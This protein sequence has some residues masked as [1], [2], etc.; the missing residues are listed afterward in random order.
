MI[1]LQDGELTSVLPYYIKS[2]TDVQA[3]SYAYH[4]AMKR[5]LKFSKRTMLYANIDEIPEELLDLMALEVRAQ[6]Y[7]ES[8]NIQVKREIIRNSLSWYI[9]G[10]TVEAVEDMVRIVLGGGK[11]TEW[12]QYGGK[13]GT[14][15]ISTEAELSPNSI[16]KLN[17]IIDRVKNKRSQLTCVSVER[18]ITQLF[19]LAAH[20]RHY[21]HMVVKDSGLN[22]SN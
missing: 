12:Y 13:A 14:F 10:G 20:S 8:M 5:M 15:R 21:P 2:S 22:N 9:K 11:V 7:D 19:R 4:M 1:K 16:K 3:I 17:E 6:Y 18:D